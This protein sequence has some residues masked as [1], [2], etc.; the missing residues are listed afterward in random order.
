LRAGIPNLIGPRSARSPRKKRVQGLRIIHAEI[1]ESS[2]RRLQTNYIDIYQVHWP[3][4][5]VDVAETAE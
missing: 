5:P 1:E 4:P 2:R 3:D